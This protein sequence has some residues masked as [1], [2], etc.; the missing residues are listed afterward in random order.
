MAPVQQRLLSTNA[1][2]LYPI[3][4]HSRPPTPLERKED[5]KWSFSSD[6]RWVIIDF[7]QCRVMYIAWL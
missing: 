3:L 5:P 1:L 6:S 7:D 4:K 2:C